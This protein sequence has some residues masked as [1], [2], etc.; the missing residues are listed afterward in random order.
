MRVKV[1]LGDW[2]KSARQRLAN[3]SE[4][5]G[6]ES[7]IL[8]THILGQSRAWL[9]THPDTS[10]DD[11]TVDRLDQLLE[12]L[13]SGEP[14]AYLLGHWEFYGRDFCVNPAVL[15]P[16]PETE[17]LVE[18]ALSWFKAH[19][20]H[21]RAVDVGTGSGCIAISLAADLKDINLIA[22]DISFKALQVAQ[23]N[24]N[25]LLVNSRLH[26]VQADLLLSLPGPFDLIVA[27]L[28]YIPEKKL[29]S[30]KVTEHEPR[31]ALDGGQDGL[32]L[33]IELLRQSPARLATPGCILLEIEFEQGQNV[34]SLAGQVYPNASVSILPDLAGLPR[35][36]KIETYEN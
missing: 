34:S 14:L 6:L 23:I 20:Y 10:L 19:P 32:R 29:V 4:T 17:L 16:R 2:I 28:P 11:K 8:V 18:S 1:E 26:L 9:A 30:L 7:E 25:R 15:I 22:T 21:R 35:I 36:L 27:N 13:V 5:P 3:Q 12:R 31:L 24:K 33:I